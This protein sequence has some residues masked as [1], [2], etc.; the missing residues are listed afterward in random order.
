MADRK[1]NPKAQALEAAFHRLHGTNEAN[2]EQCQ[3]AS[4]EVMNAPL[5]IGLAGR[6]GAGK[7]TAA[8][9]REARQ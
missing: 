8:A 5:L 1:P 6:K 2:S 3:P 9:L 4:N 7:S